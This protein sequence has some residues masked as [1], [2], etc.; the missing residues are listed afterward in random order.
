MTPAERSKKYRENHL[1]Q[2]KSYKKDYYNKNKEVY[3]ERKF[4]T[5]YKMSF[6]DYNK[7]FE[8]QGYTCAICGCTKSNGDKLFPV[9][10]CHN[11]GKVRGILCR[12][13]NVGLGH[14]KDD[15]SILQK[16]I[17]YL[18]NKEAIYGKA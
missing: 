10:H 1:E 4:K 6:Y 18:N 17:E 8:K 13:C 16:A 11:T 5:L 9:D 12:L 7:L 14:F 15:R 3:R 2:I